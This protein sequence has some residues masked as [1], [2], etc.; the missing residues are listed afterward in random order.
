MKILIAG[1]VV[2]HHRTMPLFQQKKTEELF[3]GI[4]PFIRDADISIVN[5]EAPI[6]TGALSPIKKHG[7][8]LHT[9]MEALETLIASGFNT[10]ALANNHFRDQGQSGVDATIH[11]ANALGASYVGGGRT[12]EE[13][14]RICYQK[15]G[16]IAVAIINVCENE[17]SIATEEYGGSNPLDAIDTFRDIQEAKAQSDF[18]LLV[19]HGGVEHY[20]LP[21][22]RMKKLYRFFADAGAD[23]I[24]NHHQ[25]CFSGYEIYRGTL[26]FYGL[27]NFCFDWE[28]RG[29]EGLW[30]QGYAITFDV[31]GSKSEG[32]HAEFVLHPYIQC[33]EKVGVDLRPKNYYDAMLQQLNQTIADDRLLQLAFEKHAREV[34]RRFLYEISPFTNRVI[35]SLYWRNAIKSLYPKSKLHVLKNLHWCESHDEVLKE[36]LRQL[37]ID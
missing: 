16:G 13:A 35:S 18:V 8:A 14:R 9:T 10:V 11:A 3:D 17:F 24:V 37:T 36:V 30:N 33:A 26:I 2:P 7:P 20:P 31:H 19:L 12:L 1:D 4:L 27:G 6:I 32:S 5:L 15:C 21:T 28:G 23:A 22:P 34:S 25:H 29:E